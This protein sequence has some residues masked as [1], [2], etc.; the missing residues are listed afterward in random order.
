MLLYN[1]LGM[2]KS[3]KPQQAQDGKVVLADLRE[4]LARLKIEPPYFLV[5]HS[6]GGIFA[7]LFASYYRDE[8]AGMVLLDAP[9]PEEIPVMKA[10]RIPLLFRL[11]NAVLGF[12]DKL[13]GR[14]VHSEDEQILNTV[15]M[16]NSAGEFPAIPLAVVSGGLKMPFVPKRFF[17]IH[18]SFQK[19][20][21]HLSPYAKHI[22]CEKS[23][24]FPQI[25]EPAVVCQVIKDMLQR[26]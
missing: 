10:F 22:R 24:H 6:L 21:L 17:E 7:N 5:A 18:Q 1:R 26:L 25:S 2:G 19:K 11:L 23:G 13:H 9:H 3:S 16:L 12:S 20:L 8:I 14:F 15:A 4:L